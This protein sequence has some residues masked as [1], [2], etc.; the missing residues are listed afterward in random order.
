MSYTEA[1]SSSSWP[2]NQGLLQGH[3]LQVM[4]LWIPQSAF[5]IHDAEIFKST[6]QLFYEMF[7][8]LS[9]FGA[10]S[11]LNAGYITFPV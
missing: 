9:L 5:A 10:S 6:G 4:S 11:R 8:N 2:L 1:S 3:L 7:L